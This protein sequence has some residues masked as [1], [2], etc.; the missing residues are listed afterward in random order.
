MKFLLL[1]AVGLV[2]GIVGGMI[3]IGGGVLLIPALTLGFNYTQRQ[4]AALS[5]VILLPPV[6]LPGVVQYYSQG[7]LR[8]KDLGLAAGISLAFAVGA[9]LGAGYQ[10][11][12]NESTLKFLF[13]LV[14]LY[15]AARTLLDASGAASAAT[16]GL[17]S[18]PVGWISFLALRALGRKHILRPNLGDRIRTEA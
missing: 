15:I 7:H 4:A 14:L 12:V 9:Y 2:I 10:A 3:G 13:G 16:L 17:L 6:T 8:L 11:R 18:L 1:V 5:L